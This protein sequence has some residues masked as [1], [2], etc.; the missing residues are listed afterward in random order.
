MVPLEFWTFFD[1]IFWYIDHRKLSPI[2]EVDKTKLVPTTRLKL[3]ID[4]GLQTCVNCSNMFTLDNIRWLQGVYK[5]LSSYTVS[6][7]FEFCF[8]FEFTSSNAKLSGQKSIVKL[9]FKL[10]LLWGA[11]MAQWWEHSPPTNVSQVWYPDSASYVGWVYCWFLPLLRVFFLEAP[12]L[13]SRLN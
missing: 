12:V 11:G 2:C 8:S 4:A 9:N 1:V 6:G 3:W 5:A 7:I 13:R 10:L